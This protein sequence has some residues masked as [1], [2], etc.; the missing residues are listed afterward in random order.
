MIFSALVL[1]CGGLFYCLTNLTKG[2][3]SEKQVQILPTKYSGSWSNQ[4]AALMQDLEPEAGLEEFNTNNSAYPIAEKEKIEILPTEEISL[5][6]EEISS[7][8]EELSSPAENLEELIVPPTEEEIISPSGDL[9]MY[10]FGIKK[11]SA[12]ISED[13]DNILNTDPLDT[14]ES[15]AEQLDEQI[16]GFA[17]SFVESVLEFSD[18]G[19]SE[20][21]VGQNGEGPASV[22]TSAGKKEIKNVQLR[23]SMAFEG[24]GPEDSLAIEYNTSE[25]QDNWQS[26]EEFFL[27]DSNSNAS[28]NGY[29]L[30]ALP[31]FENWEELK[32]LKIR[33]RYRGFLP[34]KGSVY[35][36]AVWLEVD[37]KEIE[38]ES[39]KIIETHS[40]QIGERQNFRIDEEPEFTTQGVFPKKGFLKKIISVFEK[41]EITGAT[42]INPRGEESSDGVIIE[43]NI[44]R[45]KKSDQ[46]S[47]RPGLY[48]LKIKAKEDEEEFI[49]EQEFLWGVLAVN[50]NKSIYLVGETAY[51]QMAALTDSGH[52]IC[53]A[54]LKLEIISPAGEPFSAV[55]ER[56]GECGPNNVT[57]VPDYFAYYQ[58]SG[59]GNY[60]MK[61]INFDNGYEITDS[62]EVRDSAS[63]EV[64]R[65]GPT[66]I[67]PPA[68][69]EMTFEI[70]ANEDFS[71]EVVEVVP[72]SFIVIGTSDVKQEIRNEEKTIIWQ[73]DW[74]AGESYE[75]KY[76]FDAPDISP[77]IYLLGPLKLAFSEERIA[78]REARKW[79]IAADAPS[80]VVT[81]Y[82][83]STAFSMERKVVR[84]NLGPNSNRVFVLVTTS[85][86]AINLYYSDNAEAVSPTWT[87]VGDVNADTSSTAPNWEA[88]DMVWDTVNNNLWIVYGC[89]TVADSNAYDLKYRRVTGIGTTPTLEA[90]TD[91]MSA[92][93][94]LT[95]SH[96][97]IAIMGDSG[98]N[99]VV[100]F[101]SEH[102]NGLATRNIAMRT[103][104]LDNV[105][106]G[107][108]RTL[109]IAWTA[110]ANSGILGVSRMNT[111]KNVLYYY[112]GTNMLA[113]RHDDSSDVDATTGWDALNGTDASR[114]TI[115]ADDPTAPA[116]GSIAGDTDSDT[117][118][119]GWL[120]G[121]QDIGTCRWSTGTACDATA[122]AK[123]T[124]AANTVGPALTTDGTTLYLVYTKNS[125]ASILVYQS[126]TFSSGTGNWSG[127]ETT[128]EDSTQTSMTYPSISRNMYD[129]VIDVVNTTTTSY[130]VRHNMIN[131]NSAPT[132]TVLQP[133]GNGDTVT[134]GAIYDI[135]YDLADSDNDVEVAMYYDSTDSGLDGTAITGDCATAVAGTG[136]TCAWDTIGM[137]V[138]SYY[139][140]GIT[141]DPSHVLVSDYSPGQ[142]TILGAAHTPVIGEVTLNS[143]TTPIILL[144]S[145]QVDIMAS[146]SITDSNGCGDISGVKAIVYRYDL[147]P[148]ASCSLNYNNCYDEDQF[149]CF[150]DGVC[151]GNTQDYNCYASS[152]SSGMWYFADPTTTNASSSHAND[153]WVV[154]IIASD[155][156]WD[157]VSS[158]SYDDD[159]ETAVDVEV[160]LALEASS[161]INYGQ[162]NPGNNTG[163]LP[164][165]I[166]IKNTGN[167]GI[168]SLI[169]GTAKPT[170]G[171]NDIDYSNQKFAS[172]SDD[173]SDEYQKILSALSTPFNVTIPK[174]TT[175]TAGANDV[176]IFW[177]MGVPSGKPTGSYINGTNL[178]SPTS[179]GT[180]L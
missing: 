97:A 99:K 116:V 88:A 96:P 76:G 10:L 79:Q 103:V 72:A 3:D 124:N 16:G 177:G 119:F 178:F 35:L 14:T 6:V 153:Q 49:K 84:T 129:K 115:S 118:W 23:L 4:E 158:N 133:D 126:R 69:Y 180:D 162:I 151:G 149:T 31:I 74:K 135:I 168:D 82:A 107:T 95:Y 128:I 110:N 33:F 170:F 154:S 131:F 90:E 26:L 77:Y 159:N 62:F 102:Y 175:N 127:T 70:K 28:N 24:G 109:D 92:S 32:N 100:F 30:Y 140:Y 75:I 146:A 161:S 13:V 104:T 50:T 101:A 145:G 137:T 169:S 17:P 7:P 138:G 105:T 55:V 65:I 41:K 29:W 8:A 122:P 132:L 120:D 111:D 112:N 54:N 59:V 36:D 106:L 113:T 157:D 114:T 167:W 68:S 80:T 83:T 47:F 81:G 174:P 78:F 160:L 43:N 22:E 123:I 2:A 150:A 64:E 121:A 143:K 20:D 46:R 139:I 125:D 144:E 179:D 117:V 66:R 173:Y 56:S 93:S 57:N 142:I 39:P 165:E 42:L 40:R 155:S 156:L 134:V 98:T 67:Y 130:Y 148:T 27:K 48:K 91:A 51:L 19:I 171:V 11:L 9:L 94:T 147:N 58:I 63:F 52:T 86:I 152:S 25:L 73:V 15:S 5:P 37:Y 172:K 164:I 163:S 44:I 21:F 53:D 60:E 71:G 108:T 141:K 34:S 176:R 45:I 166:G 61:L 1:I 38:K 89:I 12:S 18:F 136:V 85:N 87:N